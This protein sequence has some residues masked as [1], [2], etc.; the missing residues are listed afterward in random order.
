[1]KSRNTQGK[2]IECAW[3]DTKACHRQGAALRAIMKHILA[4]YWY[5]G[6]TLMGLPTNPT[7]AEAILGKAGHKTID[8]KT[9]GWKF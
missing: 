9:R 3:K 8:P 6:R 1:V 2:L 4:D 7:Y 5:V